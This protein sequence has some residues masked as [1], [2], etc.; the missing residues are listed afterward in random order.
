M[1]TV[2]LGYTNHGGT[3]SVA[4]ML[5]AN[6]ATWAHALRAGARVL[7]LPP[8]ALLTS[9][10]LAALDRRICPEGIVD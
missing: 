8:E 7:D 5:F 2:A 1:F 4:G 9:Q 3:P 10:E 6:G